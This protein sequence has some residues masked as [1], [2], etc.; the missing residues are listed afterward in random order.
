[1]KTVC[2]KL[3]SLMLVA[4]LLVSAVPFQAFATE[5]ETTAATEAAVET[6]V[7]TEPVVETTVATEPVVETTA[8]TEPVVETT[9]ATEAPV[10]TTAATESPVQETVGDVVQTPAAA[11]ITDEAEIHYIIS[12][13]QGVAEAH[14]FCVKHIDTK[15]GAKVSGVPSSSEVM[16]RY[17]QI[18]GSSTGKQFSHWSLTENGTAVNLNDLY[19]TDSNT[20]D[21]KVLYVYAVIVV[22]VVGNGYFQCTGE[23]LLAIGRGVAKYQCL[24]VGLLGIPY[25]LIK[26]FYTTM[27][28]VRT[29]VYGKLVV[30][31]TVQLK[32]S[33]G[34]AV[35][36]SSAHYAKVAVATCQNIF[37][38]TMTGYNVCHFAVAVGNQ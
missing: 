22:E 32:A 9:A 15:V 3:L 16:T 19:V 24:L 28:V 36:I 14:D 38:R 11:A 1:M 29:V 34:Y 5:G 37:D 30:Y 27:Q 7:A 12:G 2:N 10:E 23:T 20:T 18:F 17:A 31:I 33:A 26:T 6:T 25:L 4:V 35:G 8:V 13:A 21:K